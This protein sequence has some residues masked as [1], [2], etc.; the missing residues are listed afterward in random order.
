MVVVWLQTRLG[1]GFGDGDTIHDAGLG[2]GLER[3]LHGLAWL[4]QLKLLAW[5]VGLDSLAA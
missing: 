2:S 1:H 5:H 4:Q 3:L